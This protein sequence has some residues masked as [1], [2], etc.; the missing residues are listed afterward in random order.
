MYL[1]ITTA[2]TYS[3]VYTQI[4]NSSFRR[5]YDDRLSLHQAKYIL[6]ELEPFLPFT[7]KGKDT[8]HNIITDRLL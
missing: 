2:Y 6:D 4:E 1:D 8:H 7:A 3:E 5:N